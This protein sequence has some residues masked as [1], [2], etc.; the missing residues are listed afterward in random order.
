[1][2]RW[3]LC[4]RLA[5]WGIGTVAILFFL[6][7]VVANASAMP[8]IAWDARAFVAAA[9]T[10]G[11]ALASIYLGATAWWLLVIDQGIRRPW[12]RLVS[13][14]TISQFGKYLPGNVGQFVGR[15][16]MARGVDIP[17]PAT[18][19]TLVTETLWNVGTG[20]GV[21]ALAAYAFLDGR[22]PWWPRGLDGAWLCALFVALL[23]IPWL[24]IAGTRH[25]PPRLLN[26]FPA[27]AHLRPPTF[28]VAARVSLLFL[29]N[30]GC[31]GGALCMQAA[32]FFGAPAIPWLEAAGFCAIAWLAGYLLPGAPAG[33]GV[34]EGVLLAL[35]APTTGESTAIALGITL[36]LGATIADIM[37]F[38][39]GWLMRHLDNRQHKRG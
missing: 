2:T 14:F 7:R 31:M 18:L 3:R 10:V 36:R 19:A 6:Q 30:Y 34:R 37:A 25:L 35:L 28:G 32:A 33:L 1:M 16:V 15:V 5:A 22:A 4:Q 8:H 11:L 24:G 39:A 38:A 21:S 13:L 27:A 23:A 9:A 26:R 17:V 29:A 20:L 12:R